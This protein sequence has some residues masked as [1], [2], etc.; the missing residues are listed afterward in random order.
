MAT[1]RLTLPIYLPAWIHR[2]LQ[3][4]KRAV[5]PPSPAAPTI[6]GERHVEWSFISAEIPARPGKALE[7]GCE[8]GYLSLL[9]ARKG[10]HVVALDLKEQAFPWRDANVEFLRGDI[11]KLDFAANTFDLVVNCSSVEHVGLSGRYGVTQ[12]ENDGDIRAMKRLWQLLKPG[13]MLLM[14]APCGQDAVMAPWHRVYGANRLPRL[15]S[16]FHVEKE[17]YWVKDEANRWIT[18]TREAALSFVP[19][20]DNENP[21][22]SAY[23]LGCFVLRKTSDA[24][25]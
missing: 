12:E 18:S 6:W 7:F 1:V 10:F 16:T 15:L 3:R 5:S 21:H 23:A 22:N 24:S 14:T 4:M 13:G 17:T 20:G 8:Q 11:L 9:L 19:R 2:Q 25:K